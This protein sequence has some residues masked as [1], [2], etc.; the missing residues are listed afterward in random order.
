QSYNQDDVTADADVAFAVAE[1]ALSER[2]EDDDVAAAVAAIASLSAERMAESPSRVPLHPLVDEESFAASI[3]RVSSAL[4]DVLGPM[5]EAHDPF[6]VP[7]EL[8]L[9]KQPKGDKKRARTPQ[10]ERREQR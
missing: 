7:A 9:R 1:P 8:R 2:T 4:A 10:T 6:E 3:A 5:P